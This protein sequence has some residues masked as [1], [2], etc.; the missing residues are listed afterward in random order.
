MSKTKELILKLAKDDF[1]K[2]FA[3]SYLGTIWAFVQPVV[4]VLVYWFVFEKALGAGS[5]VGKGGIDVPYVLWLVAGLVPWFFFSEALSSGT[6]TLLDYNYLV[7]KVVF[8]VEILPLV[9]V[10]SASFVHLFFICFSVF[11]YICYG[12]YPDF[13]VLQVIYYS[14]CMFVLVIGLSYFTSSVLVFFRDLGQIVNIA[15]QV[16]IWATP[17]M[18]NYDDMV[19]KGIS[20]VLGTILKANPMFYIVQGYRDAFINKCGFWEHPGMTLYF[21]VFTLIIILIGRHVFKKL[22]PH[23]ADV[24]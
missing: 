23:F 24:L 12:M 15:L 20:P 14:F 4:T 19:A 11:L 10:I 18:W 6:N 1:K 22:K 2:K 8:Q 7:K 3:G 9:K 13:Y 5:R 21:W 17:I 16:G